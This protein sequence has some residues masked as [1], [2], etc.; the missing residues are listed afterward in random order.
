MTLSILISTISIDGK[1]RL[2][3]A[4]LPEYRNVSYIIVWQTPGQNHPAKVPDSFVRP[5]I[6][7]IFSD[8]KG[9]SRSRNIAIAAAESDVCLIAD[10]DITFLPEAFNNIIE[11]F[12]SDERLDIAL[13]RI[14]GKKK[15]YPERRIRVNG[16]LPHGYWVTSPEIAFRRTSIQNKLRFREDFGLGAPYFTAA[17]E[18]FWITDAMRLGLAIDIIPEEIV[19][20]PRPSSGES[21]FGTNPGFPASQGA[22]IRYNHGFTNG[23]PRVFLF[24]LRCYLRRQ[25]AFWPTLK[26]ALTGFTCKTDEIS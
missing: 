11:A 10:D 19:T 14:K 4:S 6:R 25:G 8:S 5:D 20:H 13:F 7:I 18:S 24:A 22:Y 26:H 3:P 15:S 12:S 9:I 2:Q 21:C 1:S 17:E 16:K 23:I